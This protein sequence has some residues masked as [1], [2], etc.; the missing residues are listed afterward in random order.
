MAHRRALGNNLNTTRLSNA[1]KR[2]EVDFSNLVKTPKKA[3]RK[4]STA[5]KTTYSRSGIGYNDIFKWD[6][7]GNPAIDRMFKMFVDDM[8]TD[9]KS[10]GR[11]WAIATRMMMREVSP[12][13]TGNLRE[14]VKILSADNIDAATIGEHLEII[15]NS[16]VIT[17]IVGIN[18]KAILP[19]PHRKHIIAGPRAG[20]MHT[21]P[22]Y[23]YAED[24][25]N[26]ILK[27]KSEGYQGYDF[28]EKWQ[29]IAQKNMERIF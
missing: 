9:V 6:K 1:V 19:P 7:T 10:K 28:L 26:I 16:K 8:A 4:K 13:L 24:A 20:K 23:N 11:Q 18:E 12:V 25:N 3:S 27:L 14:S 22:D 2:L 29:Q 5:T 15:N 21:M 17:Y